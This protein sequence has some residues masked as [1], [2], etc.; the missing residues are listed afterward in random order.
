MARVVLVH[1][2]GQQA[3]SARQQIDQWLPSLVKGILLS[4]HPA[5]GSV[6]AELSP[7]IGA[8]PSDTIAMAFY[9][10]L[11]LAS[12][13]QG[14]GEDA[15][16][17]AIAVAE[18]L[19]AALLRSALQRG[20]QQ[21]DVRLETEASSFLHQIDPSRT[22]IQAAGAV[23]RSA[24][25][26]LDGNHWLAA[27]IFGLAQRAKPDLLQVARY[28]TDDQIRSQVQ[29][30]IADLFTAGTRVVISHSL[31]T[32]AAW[33]RC[34]QIS[35]EVSALI[36]M[37]SPLGLDNIVYPRLQ[38]APPTFPP[39]IKRW[40]NVAHPDDIVA[41]APRLAPLFPSGDHRRV[42]DRTPRSAGNHHSATTYLEQPE[43]GHEIAEAL[44]KE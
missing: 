32:V 39:L 17:E 38:P 18:L 3:G 9:G 20:I 4:G 2:I 1:G 26:M 41:V 33:E 42:D 40:L 11:F 43:V 36:T 23:A 7:S 34:Q 28:L 25:A 37:G 31:G 10:D 29:G 35:S 21:G 30:R 12:G 15:S 14:G 5:A 22:E 6:A 27:R 13:V 44:T 24:M 16:P 8:E 19:A